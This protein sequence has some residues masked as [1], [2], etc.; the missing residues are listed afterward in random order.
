VVGIKPGFLREANRVFTPRKFLCALPAEEMEQDKA[1][2]RWD[3][4][5]LDWGW[6]AL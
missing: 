5:L 4:P 3:F 6:A 1:L 2:I